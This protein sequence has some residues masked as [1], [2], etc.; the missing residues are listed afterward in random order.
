MANIFCCAR[1]LLAN[2]NVMRS[3]VRCPCVCFNHTLCERLSAGR[4]KRC[5]AENDHVCIG[6]DNIHNLHIAP[7]HFIVLIHTRYVL[8][9]NHSHDLNASCKNA[10]ARPFLIQMCFLERCLQ[11]PRAHHADCGN[12]DLRIFFVYCWVVAALALHRACTATMSRNMCQLLTPV[13][14]PNRRPHP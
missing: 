6:V 12:G 13:R 2:Y 10:D 9:N 1:V 11:P 3:Y 4:E 7:S 5:S 8:R 14:R